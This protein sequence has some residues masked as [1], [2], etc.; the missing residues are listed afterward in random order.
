MWPI[1]KISVFL[2]FNPG[3]KSNSAH[4]P[5]QEKKKKKIHP[6]LFSSKIIFGY[7]Q[8][9]TA[10]KPDWWSGILFVVCR[11]EEYPAE[12]DSQSLWNPA[13]E[14]ENLLC[15]TLFPAVSCSEELKICQNILPFVTLLIEMYLLCSGSYSDVNTNVSHEE[16]LYPKNCSTNT[17]YAEYSLLKQQTMYIQ[18][19]P[20]RT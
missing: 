7:K 4:F 2:F 8:T 9:Q 11:Q 3:K 20:Y 18:M 19:S 16:S 1:F 5:F 12:K 17:R 15:G 14:Q 6:P 13:G 10:H